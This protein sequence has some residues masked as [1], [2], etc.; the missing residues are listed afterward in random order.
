MKLILHVDVFI[1]PRRRIS[2][3]CYPFFGHRTYDQDRRKIQG[4]SDGYLVNQP[5]LSEVMGYKE[6]LLSL[7]LGECNKRK[8][9][10]YKGFKRMGMHL[11][12][13]MDEEKGIQGIRHRH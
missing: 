8:K 3:S 12:P 10:R 13:M 1:S 11:V 2:T 6:S 9:R 7:N 4:G 5:R